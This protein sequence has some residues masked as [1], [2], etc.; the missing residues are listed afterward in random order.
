MISPAA[1]SRS[2]TVG[3]AIR[4]GRLARGWS[5]DVLAR[6]IAQARRAGGESVDPL[7]VKTQLSRWENGH[8][9]PDRFTR[10]VLADV[11][12]T[13]VEALFGVQPAGDLPR[14]VL[15]SA[16]VTVHT[17]ELLRARRAIHAQT[18]ASFGPAEASVLVSHDLMTIDG[19]LRVAP[20]PLSTELHD[21]AAMIAEL[22]GWIAQDTGDIDQAL[23]CT[24]RAHAHAQAA[25]NPGLEAMIL[26]RWANVVAATDP[27]ASA[28]LSQRAEELAS[29]LPPSRLHAAIARQRASVAALLDDRL[30]FRDQIDRAGDYAGAPVAQGELAPYADTA[31][32]ASEQ[33]EGRLVLGEPEVAVEALARH[34][35]A[36]APGQERDHGVAL[37]RWLHAL[38]ASGECQTAFDHCD[39]VLLAYERAPSVRSRS[40]LHAIMRM[41]PVGDQLHHAALRRR[42]AVTIEGTRSR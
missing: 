3:A 13:T 35:Q 20:D 14:P 15:V 2:S 8:V 34:V 16:H 29:R 42:I 38:A 24:T 9:V 22:G 28:T 12:S 17:V 36:W 30:L 7:S 26:M 5:Q 1:S 31:Y 10:Q 33:A 6:R 11:F 39:D 23:I 37:A 19:L 32:I 18:E 4:Q 21:V 27:R 41:R 40:A 25:G